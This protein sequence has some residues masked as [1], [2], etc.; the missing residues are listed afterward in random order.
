[1]M[2]FPYE[3]AWNYYLPLDGIM[4]E[5]FAFIDYESAVWTLGYDRREDYYINPTPFLCAPVAWI[6]GKELKG[7]KESFD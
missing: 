4:T 6:V 5:S 7:L 2:W 3:E 1:M